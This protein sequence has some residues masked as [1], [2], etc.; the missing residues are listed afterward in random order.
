MQFRLVSLAFAA[1][2]AIAVSGQA[3]GI[4]KYRL[5]N[6]EIGYASPGLVPEGATV[7]TTNYEPDGRLSRRPRS[8]PKVAPK[9]KP[10]APTQAATA[11]VEET[12]PNDKAR[13]RA[14][15]AEKAH[16]AQRELAKAERDHE[17]WKTRCRDE[18]ERH[19]LYELSPGCSTYEKS[20]LDAALE[21]RRAWAE[22][23]LF[24]A[25][26]TSGEC[27]PGYIR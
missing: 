7:E 15:W 1:V 16:A 25:C 2:L 19:S 3:G 14:K 6:G 24:N 20:R 5:P 13:I 11:P 4:V 17:T 21:E 9:K 22:D 23:G 12:E 18:E 10:A 27:L 26:R 8:E